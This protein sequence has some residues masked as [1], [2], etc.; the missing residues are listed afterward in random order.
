[1]SVSTWHAKPIVLPEPGQPALGKQAQQV[2]DEEVLIAWLAACRRPDHQDPSDQ[3]AA[4][5]LVLDRLLIRLEASSRVL[6]EQVSRK[7]G[8]PAGTT[9]GAAAVELRTAVND[10]DG[11]RCSSYPAAVFHLHDRPDGLDDEQ[12][13]S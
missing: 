9:V 7:L 13:L 5:E 1:M 4:A 11:P 8:L 6:P 2:A 10:P 3:T 12:D